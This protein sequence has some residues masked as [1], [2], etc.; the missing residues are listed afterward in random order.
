[1]R[2]LGKLTVG[3]LIA[4]STAFP[5]TIITFEDLPNQYFLNGGDQN[6]GSFYAGVTFGPNV[7]GLGPGDYDPVAFPPHS[8]NVVVFDQSDNSVDIVFASDQSMVGLWYVSLDP[9]TLSAFD[10]SNTLL[11]PAAMGAANTDG[12]NGTD[13]FISDSFAAIRSVTFSG[14]AGD[15]VLDDVT[16]TPAVASVPEPGSLALAAL[17]I[18]AIVAAGIRRQTCV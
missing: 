10:A 17:G 3:F 4:A 6:I 18:L 12:T 16:Y 7:T 13:S 9:V 5:T 1:M 15:F 8:G 14:I 2:C 11:G